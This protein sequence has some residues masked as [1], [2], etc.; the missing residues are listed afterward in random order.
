MN[1]IYI[2]GIQ[3]IYIKQSDIFIYGWDENF[4]LYIDEARGCKACM[5][6]SKY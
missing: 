6:N 1:I 5:S 4:V 2:V 3:I